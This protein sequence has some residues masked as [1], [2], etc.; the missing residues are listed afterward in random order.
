MVNVEKFNIATWLVTVVMMD[1][2]CD[3]TPYSYTIL[4]ALRKDKGNQNV[5]PFKFKQQICNSSI[6]YIPDLFSY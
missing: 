5:K 4:H 6:G 2:F 1:Q 3:R